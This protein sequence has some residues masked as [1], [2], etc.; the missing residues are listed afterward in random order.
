MTDN[1]KIAALEAALDAQIRAHEAFK[2]ELTATFGPILRD[3]QGETGLKSRQTAIEA[4]VYALKTRFDDLEASTT[5]SAALKEA[6]FLAQNEI[7]D[8]KLQLQ[9]QQTAEKYALTRE[10]LGRLMLSQNIITATE[11]EEAEQ[12]EETQA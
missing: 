6:L 11:L 8:L 5:T 10:K 1:A 4:Q 12:S 2:A 9:R 3:M 7:A